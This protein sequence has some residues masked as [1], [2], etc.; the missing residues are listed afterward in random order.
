MP[1]FTAAI[2]AVLLMAASQ[3]LFKRA[4]SGATRAAGALFRWPVLAG[5][6]LN[7]LSA[8]CWVFALS[9][10]ELNRAFPLLSLNFALVPLAAR[11]FFGEPISRRRA[12]AIG[13]IAVGVC[14]AAAA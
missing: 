4:A 1:E 14:V 9:R 7:A 13:C 8:A 5:L 6:T 10:L 11:L 2:S 3:L 12:A